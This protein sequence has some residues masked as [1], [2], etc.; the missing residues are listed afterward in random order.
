MILK[1]V[2]RAGGAPKVLTPVMSQWRLK[3]VTKPCGCDGGEKDL[4]DAINKTL[5]GCQDMA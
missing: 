1:G 2:V 4:E 3:N 5:G